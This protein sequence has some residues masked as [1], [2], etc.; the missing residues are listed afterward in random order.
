MFARPSRSSF[1]KKDPDA[2]VRRHLPAQC[3]SMVDRRDAD[4]LLRLESESVEH[5]IEEGLWKNHRLMPP[6]EA[7]CRR[8]Q[9]H[10]VL[11]YLL[12][13]TCVWTPVRISFLFNSEIDEGRA[14]TTRIG[15]RL[16]DYFDIVIDVCFALDVVLNFRT[17]YYN[18]HK[19]LITDWKTIVKR[20]M[21]FWFWVETLATIPWDAVTTV[22]QVPAPTL[23]PA[24]PAGQKRCACSETHGC[25]LA[26]QQ[27]TRLRA[28][29]RAWR[30]TTHSALRAPAFAAPSSLHAPPCAP[31]VKSCS[32]PS[33]LPLL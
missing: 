24:A 11:I 4:A 6:V 32:S 3:G 7:S 28:E 15:W 14:S 19:E 22:F 16:L 2:P 8:Q 33:G 21:A 25:E 17:A 27:R 9:F 18:E 23:G 29:S 12:Y 30:R 20:Y 26:A 10:S 13:Y 1:A 5:V 31:N